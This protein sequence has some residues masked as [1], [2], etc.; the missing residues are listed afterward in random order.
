MR[1]QD[2]PLSWNQPP[3]LVLME[4]RPDGALLPILRILFT[5]YPVTGAG[6]RVSS[7]RAIKLR[8][9]HCDYARDQLFT[10]T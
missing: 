10:V 9:G 7:H 5:K 6:R 8:L 4:C 3:A 1:R 2:L